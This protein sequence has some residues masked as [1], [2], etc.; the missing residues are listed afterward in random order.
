MPYAVLQSHRNAPGIE[1]LGAVLRREEGGAKFQRLRSRHSSLASRRQGGQMN[2]LWF[3]ILI[4]FASAIHAASGKLREAWVNRFPQTEWVNVF[5][6]NLGQV[7]M[8]GSST[9]GLAIVLLDQDGTIVA[10]TNDPA[11]LAQAAGTD[12]NGNIYLAANCGYVAVVCATKY[13]TDLGSVLWHHAYGFPIGGP[14]AVPKA[15][16]VR[17]LVA[18]ED[19]NIYLA[20][21]YSP[22]AANP[23]DVFALSFGE[24]GSRWVDTYRRFSTDWDFALGVRRTTTGRVYVVGAT[25][26]VN[27]SGSS[28]VALAYAAGGDQFWASNYVSSAPTGF[29]YSFWET[30]SGMAVD[31]HDNL[32]VVGSN[33]EVA[34][35]HRQVLAMKIVPAGQILWRALFD[36][37]GGNQFGTGVAADRADDVIVTGP[38]GTL[39]Y[40]PGGKLK[41]Y[42]PEVGAAVRIDSHDDIVL[43]GSVTNAS[44]L[45]V[46]QTTKL[47]R[48][49]RKI[50]QAHYDTGAGSDNLFVSM[51][52]DERD[53]AYVGVNSMNPQEAAVI[54]YVERG[55]VA[56]EKR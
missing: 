27:V 24:S 36:P 19:G 31:S 26:H 44:G 9:G 22:Y 21:D 5:P 43:S 42:S 7:A 20:G 18:D 56:R 45:R 29:Q 13:Q 8:V 33:F 35:G 48:H 55:Q 54:K 30:P 28:I 51:F 40:S 3:V 49:G 4:G 53:S 6:N 16:N 46:V 47:D 37:P 12:N 38:S 1:R 17:D 10:R 41:W 15:A 50:G 2:R 52:V 11:G 23:Y 39:K 34:T 32:L 14:R 25:H